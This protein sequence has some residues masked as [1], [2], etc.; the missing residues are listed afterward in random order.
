MFGPNKN[1][2]AGADVIIDEKTSLDFSFLPTA[3]LNTKSDIKPDTQVNTNPAAEAELLQKIEDL[4]STFI[5]KITLY[6]SP[7]ASK[8]T[9][10]KQ[11]IEQCQ[12]K[13]TAGW[14][15]AETA[16][17]QA[18]TTLLSLK[19]EYEAIKQ[20]VVTIQTLLE[21]PSAK[22]VAHQQKINQ[23]LAEI[24]ALEPILEPA[25]ARIEYTVSA[26]KAIDPS[27]IKQAYDFNKLSIE[28]IVLN[29]EKFVNNIELFIKASNV[30]Q[31]T[32]STLQ[33]KLTTYQKIKA[34]FEAIKNI[35]IKERSAEQLEK[36]NLLGI[37]LEKAI[38]AYSAAKA[39]AKTIEHAKD[40]LKH[41]DN[42][43]QKTQ[44]EIDTAKLIEGKK[45]E[46]NDLRK[47]MDDLMITLTDEPLKIEPQL[48][49]LV[50][51]EQKIAEQEK[52]V[53]DNQIL[54]KTHQAA[55]DYFQAEVQ[56]LTEIPAIEQQT[57][58]ELPA[59]ILSPLADH[60]HQEPLL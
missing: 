16:V 25:L 50:E 45:Q 59:P 6:L 60:P 7:E 46:N 56:K 57:H 51:T 42:W 34:D 24:K 35:P 54:S 28:S 12:D 20:A 21:D 17:L 14:K 47:A 11:A 48:A 40:Y 10:H 29:K 23:N 53:L 3:E 30:V 44:H 8:A 49:K 37:E 19:S 26:A 32:K 5:K 31:D 39:S 36:D 55:L 52:V 43:S 13:N 4:S 2:I 41:H 58:V 15:Q 38:D 33:E 1:A 22:L 9:I 27:L 18:Q